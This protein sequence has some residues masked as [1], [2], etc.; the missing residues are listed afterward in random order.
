M[1]PE[2]SKNK[3]LKWFVIVDLLVLNAGVGYLLYKLFVSTSSVS[4]PNLG[5]D[6]G[7][8]VNDQCGPDCQ[9]YI[10]SKLVKSSPAPTPAPTSKTVTVIPP[11]VK[12]K[13]TT[14][15]PISVGGSTLNQNWTDLPGTEFYFDLAN[16]PGL[17]SIYF[18]ANIRLLNGN[19]IA[20]VQLYD[21]NHSIGVQ[22]SQA[23]TSNQVST[24]VES[25]QVSFWSGNNLIRIQAK[26]LT[27]D[28]AVFD[29]GRIRIITEN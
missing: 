3:F 27:A 15:L 26:S 8:V 14:Y 29:G 7:V 18:E 19:G 13:T 23:Q 5:G 28:T 2:P 12:V 6:R 20:Y 24:A 25:G 11:R 21:T 10:D 16:Y 1:D 22:G 17:V 9:S 4:P